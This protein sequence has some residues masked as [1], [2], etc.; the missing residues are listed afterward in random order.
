[1][2][3]PFRARRSRNP[4]TLS[5]RP[6]QPRPLGH[7][8]ARRRPCGRAPAQF[9]CFR[10]PVLSNPAVRSPPRHLLIA[11]PRGRLAHGCRDVRRRCWSIAE[12]LVG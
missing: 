11:E 4:V 1:M 6:A 5:R 9:R 7:H 8:A 3:I 12:G 10:R 2:R